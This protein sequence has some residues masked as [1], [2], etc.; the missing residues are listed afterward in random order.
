M[1]KR[2]TSI[3]IY[4]IMLMVLLI[5]LIFF[6]VVYFRSISTLSGALKE[7]LEGNAVLRATE[8]AMLV[9]SELESLKSAVRNIGMISE[10]Q[11]MVWKTQQL[12]LEEECERLGIESIQIVKPDGSARST[13]NYQE[14]VAESTAF[15]KAMEGLVWVSDPMERSY[16]GKKVFLCS[17]PVY[18]KNRRVIGAL[19]AHMELRFFDGVFHK[20]E[21]GSKES[22]FIIDRHGELLSY[23]PMAQVD[24]DFCRMISQHFALDEDHGVGRL[25]DKASGYL[26][27]GDSERF[28]AIRSVMDTEW[29]LV[30]TIERGELL[31]ELDAAGKRRLAMITVMTLFTVLFTIYAFLYYQQ[32][33]TLF[34]LQEATEK[35]SLLLKETK[36]VDKTRIEFFANI[37]HELRTPLNVILSSIQLLSMQMKNDPV[38]ENETFRKYFGM[39]KRNTLRLSRLISNLIDTTRIQSSFYELHASQCDI[40]RL[41]RE[42]SLSVEGY[43]RKKGITLNFFTDVQQK[44]IICDIDKVERILLNLLSNAIKFTDEGGRISVFL[45]DQGSMVQLTVEDTGIGIPQDKLDQIFAR[46]QK[47][48]KTRTKNY[49]GSGI[50]LSLVKSMVEI[51]GGTIRVISETGKGSKFVIGLPVYQ[52]VREDEIDYLIYDRTQFQQRLQMEMAEFLSLDNTGNDA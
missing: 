6:I 2:Q 29:Y 38:F 17:T 13:L 1:N 26:P 12:V 9:H 40:V 37:S 47:V 25:L 11:S 16:D 21:K 36:E 27:Y 18:D 35:S 50:G 19:I 22:C 32:Q 10:I 34:N 4:Q 30:Q 8:N 39:I 45:N 43:V 14:N 51:H 31:Y 48:E 33:Q 41:V 3:R 24:A 52:D 28:V 42:I 23:S 7:S 5:S 44:I 46:Y 49:E 15:K 20:M